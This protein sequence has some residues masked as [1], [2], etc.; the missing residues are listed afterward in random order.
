MSSKRSIENPLQ[1]QTLW[2]L[3]ILNHRQVDSDSS[4]AGSDSDSVQVASGWIIGAF[5]GRSVGGILY[6]IYNVGP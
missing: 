6:Y 5:A 1:P 3:K 2:V 4:E